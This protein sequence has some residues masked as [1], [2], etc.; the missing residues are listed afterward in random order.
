MRASTRFWRMWFHIQFTTR[1]ILINLGCPL[2]DQ[3]VPQPDTLKLI[4][5]FAWTATR[6]HVLQHLN[7]VG[8]VMNLEANAHTAFNDLKWGIEAENKNGTVRHKSWTYHDMTDHYSRS[9]MYTGGFL[10]AVHVAQDIFNC[11]MMKRLGLEEVQ[12][13]SNLDWGQIH[14]YATFDLQ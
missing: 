13:P 11:R 9:N 1:S 8:N 14:Y 2:H 3:F 7:G 5:M 10:I 12:K 6:D 4:A